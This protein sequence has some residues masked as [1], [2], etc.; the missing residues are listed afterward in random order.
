MTE[1]YFFVLSGLGYVVGA[2]TA[3]LAGGDWRWGLRVTPI[4]GLLAVFL[5]LCCMV[6]P[7]RGESEGHGD[8]KATSYAKDLRSL[9]KNKSFVFS[10][11]AFTCVAFCTGA[12]SWWGPNFIEAAARAS[13]IDDDAVIGVGK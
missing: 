3:K 7:P 12:L 2:E 1:G 8:L 9:A 10:T 5:I 6:D 13:S 4:L 11:I